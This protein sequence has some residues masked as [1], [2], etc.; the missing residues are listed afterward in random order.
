MNF[1]YFLFFALFFWLLSSCSDRS[2]DGIVEDNDIQ[3][4][5]PDPHS[6]AQPEEAVIQAL[7]LELTVDFAKQQ[8]QGIARYDIF[9]KPN[10]DQI[11]LDTRDLDIK[12]VTLNDGQDTANFQL[13]DKK[14]HL[15]RALTIDITPE[16]EHINIHYV[17][18]P[19]AAA[20]QWLT[21][22]QTAGKKHPF[23]FTQ[24]QAILARS[25]IPIQDSPG[26][27]FTY[28][29]TVKVP[30][31]LMA[32]MS[33]SNPQQVNDSGV[34]HFTME[35]PIPSYLMALAVGDIRF[36]DI[37]PR[38][39][40]YA[41]PSVLEAALY[42][43][44]DMEK[45]LKSAEAL[46]GPYV[47]DRYD[48][49]VLPPSFPFGGMENPRL[50]FL[51]P[52]VL[53]GDR[54]LTAI[55]AHELAHS[56]SGNLVTN[57][58]WND[59]WL[60]EGFTV[61]FE[62]RIMEQLYGKSYANML[63]LLGYQDLQE[64]I[65]ALKAEGRIADTHLKLDLKGRDPDEGL[66]DI[67]YEKGALFLRQIESVVGR[68][69]F[70]AFLTRYFDA[71]AFQTMTTEGFITYLN[72]ELIKGDSALANAIQV[73]KWVYGPGI[74]DP[75]PVPQSD[76]FA[77]VNDAISAWQAG[78]PASQL[79][80]SSWSTHEWLH[81]LRNLPDTL[82]Q[83]QMQALDEAFGFTQSGNSE[84][85]GQWLI[86]AVKNN[87]EPAYKRLEQFLVN[88]GRRKFL[89]PI[90]RA[91]AATEKGMARA[92]EIYRMARPN[93]HAVSYHTIDAVLNWQE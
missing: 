17:T 38:T 90:Y 42:E 34:Y 52:T 64:E 16:T 75:H 11:V 74:P 24:S 91:L 25:W 85:V 7:E 30:K 65:A 47:W 63:Q 31:G 27:R 41:E 39:G 93:Y 51:T 77:K 2:A 46:Y 43:F 54:S 82:S 44:A 22:Q 28:E 72:Q 13:L 58:T 60:N 40:I 78:T 37:G 1:R 89:T 67:A 56:W 18:S 86:M 33:A 19:D 23:L 20:L 53:A 9:A 92:E 70:D 21:P 8:L 76:R 50:T 26:I 48:V 5:A 73:N 4:K 71:F 45:M 55:I 84:I 15:G 69:T 29:A 57:A 6:F 83:K 87:Y 35:Q 62:G 32:V 49:I 14:P 79:S 12:F 61:Y 36:G 68:D 88:V 66:T 59:F 3:Q 81:F 10:A 80:T